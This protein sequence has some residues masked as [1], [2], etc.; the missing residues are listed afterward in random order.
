MTE[1]D[2]MEIVW[3]RV[4]KLETMVLENIP[5]GLTRSQ[6]DALRQMLY[7]GLHAYFVE[8]ES[9]YK[10]RIEVLQKRARAGRDDKYIKKIRDEVQE[11]SDGIDEREHELAYEIIH[12]WEEEHL[13]VKDAE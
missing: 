9:T 5:I 11:T 10:K 12:K 7:D 6:R 3:D 8:V 1:K 4:N 13:Q 2:L